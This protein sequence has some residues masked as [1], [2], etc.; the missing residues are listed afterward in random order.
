MDKESNVVN[1]DMDTKIQI[2]KKAMTEMVDGLYGYTNEN[3]LVRKYNG[4][5]TMV[6]HALDSITPKK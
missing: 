2:S 5:V 4:D 6:L 3:N 1:I